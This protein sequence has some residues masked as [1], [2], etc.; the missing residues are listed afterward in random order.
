MK[1]IEKTHINFNTYANTNVL[2]AAYADSYSVNSGICIFVDMFLVDIAIFL[3][4][5]SKTRV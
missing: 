3:L 5:I 2:F 4:N 1:S